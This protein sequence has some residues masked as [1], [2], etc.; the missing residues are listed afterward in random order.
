MYLIFRLLIFLTKL[1]VAWVFL[2]FEICM[3]RSVESFMV[4]IP[5][6]VAASQYETWSQRWGIFRGFL[7]IPSESCVI[8]KIPVLTKLCRM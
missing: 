2:K 3:G 8:S 4:L 7:P 6:S 1:F 5:S